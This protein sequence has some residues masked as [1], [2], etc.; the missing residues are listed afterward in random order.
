MLRPRPHSLSLTACLLVTALT[1]LAATLLPQTAGAD[2]NVPRPT[3]K[4]GSGKTHIPTSPK[5]QVDPPV[6]PTPLGDQT[7]ITTHSRSKKSDHA[8]T[9]TA[10]ATNL[11]P[12]SQKPCRRHVVVTDPS[13]KHEC[14]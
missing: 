2:T 14:L 9:P 5:P 6:H 11:P 1:T 12:P 10:S 8:R 13:Q 4:S 7:R 3:S